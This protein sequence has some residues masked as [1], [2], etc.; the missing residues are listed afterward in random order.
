MNLFVCVC[1]NVNNQASIAL[2]KHAMHHGKTKHFAIKLHFIRDLCEKL[3][4]K[5]VYTRT[6]K[7]PVWEQKLTKVWDNVRDKNQNM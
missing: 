4:T 2:S 1:L 3:K 5:L 6:E 7:Q